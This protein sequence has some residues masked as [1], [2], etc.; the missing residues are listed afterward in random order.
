MV[1]LAQ[2][3]GLHPEHAAIDVRMRV[4]ADEA[5]DL[6]FDEQKACYGHLRDDV[7][8]DL[9]AIPFGLPAMSWGFEP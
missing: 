4:V 7:D 5:G 8:L 9:H 3:H 2:V 1:C 6:V